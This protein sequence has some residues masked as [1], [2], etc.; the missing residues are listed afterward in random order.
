MKK[1]L[2]VLIALAIS[3]MACRLPSA[4]PTATPTARPTSTT[5][6]APSA[7]ATQAGPSLDRSDHRSVVAWM[8]YEFQRGNYAAIQE[9][10]HG[11]GAQFAPA[12]VGFQPGSS[13][14]A[15]QF[16]R[17]FQDAISGSAV[18]EAV[19]PPDATPKFYVYFSGVKL[20]EDVTGIRHESN[21]VNFMFL[22]TNGLWELVAVVPEWDDGPGY[23]GG[24]SSAS[25]DSCR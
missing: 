22:Q 24:F 5:R 14:N 21:I 4:S 20:D 17:E 12:R 1:L 10:I 19:R 18:C 13:G 25:L 8:A 15:L 3:I 16:A 6:P 11:I 23:F 9:L 2:L 7:T